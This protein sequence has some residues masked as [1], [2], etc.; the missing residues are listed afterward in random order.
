MRSDGIWHPR[1]VA[2]TCSLMHGD[3]LVLADAAFPV[4]RD[5]EVIDLG[6]ARRQP[7]LLPVLGWMARRVHAGSL[8][9]A[10]PPAR[11]TGSARPTES[12]EP[13]PFSRLL[14]LQQ[15]EHFLMRH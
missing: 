3:L 10:S 9:V 2:L 12:T 5:I 13:G 11:T 14:G 15:G 4:P 6:W 8:P 7:R 1:I